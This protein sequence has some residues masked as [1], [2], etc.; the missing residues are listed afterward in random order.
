MTTL[1]KEIAKSSP[2]ARRWSAVVAR[3]GQADGIFVYAVVTTGVYCRP[4]CPARRPRPENVRFYATAQAAEAAGFRR[5]T[6][7]KPDD[8]T[9]S[10]RQIRVVSRACRL[11][12]RSD[13]VPTL[14]ELARVFCFSPFHFQRLFKAAT[15]VSPK[16][17]AMALRQQRL[18]RSVTTAR[19]VT[20]AI[21][22]A[23]YASSSGYYG[24]GQWTLGMTASAFRRGG[25]MT[26]LRYAIGMS[27]L[28][29][30]LVAASDK[31]VAA[32]L[33]GDSEQTLIDNLRA[34]FPKSDLQPGGRTFKANV[35]AVVA[36]I[37]N[38]RASFD[39]P[40]DIQGTAFQ[41]RVW[42]ALRDIPAGSTAT[43]TDI[44]ERIRKPKAAR[45]VAAA[46]AANPLAIAVPCHR[47]VGSNGYLSGYRWGVDRKRALLDR[48]QHVSQKKMR[49][50]K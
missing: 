34:R 27:S 32:I 7:C 3:D 22:D 31:G 36:L 4:S 44:A 10:T 18:R 43:Y 1:R 49:K 5:C 13:R 19:N 14:P 46:C 15:G 24:N 40:L 45:A 38:P 2:H 39:L 41:H 33:L 50:Q 17:Y 35:K 12:E 9:F 37:E 25:K 11:I 16:A 8:E 48:E 28:G 23:G 21:F 29:Q 30:V 26:T 42:L 20:T 47:V 6:R